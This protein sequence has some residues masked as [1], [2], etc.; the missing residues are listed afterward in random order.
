MI[1]RTD[2]T[3]ESDL[4]VLNSKLCFILSIEHDLIRNPVFTLCW[5]GPS[6]WGLC[7]N[8]SFYFVFVA[9]CFARIRDGLTE[10][11]SWSI[12]QAHLNFPIIN[13]GVPLN[14]ECDRLITV[15]LQNG[16]HRAGVGDHVLGRAIDIDLRIRQQFANVQIGQT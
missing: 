12:R 3:L 8:G 5:R 13:A 10:R 15:M 2:A 16:V 4:T 7:S 6:S 1:R 11:A 14:S 9:R